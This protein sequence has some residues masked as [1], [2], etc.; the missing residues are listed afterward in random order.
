MSLDLTVFKLRDAQMGNALHLTQLLKFQ[1]L[2][3][4][5]VSNFL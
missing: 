5:R 2:E 3:N 1:Y 4:E